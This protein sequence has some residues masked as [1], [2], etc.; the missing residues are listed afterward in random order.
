ML[1]A[2]VDDHRAAGLDA[3]DVAV[4]DLIRADRERELHH[5]AAASEE[6]SSSPACVRVRAAV[7]ADAEPVAAK[8]V[9]PGNSDLCLEW[10]GPIADAVTHVGQ[11][12]MLREIATRGDIRPHAIL[13]VSSRT[14]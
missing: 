10:S 12:A 7:P 1:Q 8:R 13:A 6:M 3:V 11:L 14:S 2:V 9:E 4:M 5:L